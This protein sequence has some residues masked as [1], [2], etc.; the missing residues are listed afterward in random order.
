MQTG[1]MMET[2]MATTNLKRAQATLFGND[3]LRA[4]NFKMFPGESRNSTA[5]QI[6]AEI[7]AVIQRISDGDFDIVDDDCAV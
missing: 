5:D 6:A 2:T 4:T 1:M 7:D 3:G